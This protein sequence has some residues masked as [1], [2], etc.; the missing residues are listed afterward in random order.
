MLLSPSKKFFGYFVILSSLFIPIFLLFPEFYLGEDA[1]KITKE[2]T[3]DLDFLTKED[4]DIIL[5]YFGYVG[6]DTICTPALEQIT[7]LYKT[8]PKEKVVVYFV[9]LLD[10][11]DKEL[12]SLYADSFNSNFK[13]IYLEKHDILK[14]M[15]QL[16]IVLN[17][18]LLDKYELNHSGFLYLLQ[19]DGII[20]KYK[21]KYI[22]TTRPYSEDM[23]RKDIAILLKNEEKK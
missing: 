20:N 10:I 1:A 19:K 11:I 3:V 7:S 16:D 5:L 8:L 4:A 12:P 9:N 21:Q 15:Q 14:V 23:I 6:C 13:G 2:K 17:Q 18:S 22:Y